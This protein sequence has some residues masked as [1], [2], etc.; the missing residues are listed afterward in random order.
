MAATFAQTP[1]LPLRAASA[2]L[3]LRSVGPN[4]EKN[5]LP[6][7]VGLGLKDPRMLGFMKHL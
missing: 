7:A 6:D 5:Y 4:D 1:Q 2:L 3:I